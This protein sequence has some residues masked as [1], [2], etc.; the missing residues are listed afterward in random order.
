M[1]RDGGL[2]IHKRVLLTVLNLPYGFSEEDLVTP[3][4][5][6]NCLEE[7]APSFIEVIATLPVDLFDKVFPIF[8][9]FLLDNQPDKL[10]SGY[11]E[12]VLS[13]RIF[14]LGFGAFTSKSRALARDACL[15]MIRRLSQ[16]HRKKPSYGHTIAKLRKL[17]EQ[18]S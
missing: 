15:R 2:E 13:T 12:Y 17:S 11:L 14:E 18:L 8:L 9:R 1:L 4:A 6:R 3:Q 5:V 7:R 16:L 10:T